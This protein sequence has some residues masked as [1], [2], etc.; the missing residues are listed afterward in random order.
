M[1]GQ[2]IFDNDDKKIQWRKNSLFN[3]GAGT[4]HDTKRISNKIKINK[5]DFISITLVI[6]QMPL[7]E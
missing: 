6:Q 1:Y 7:G 4:R 2:L 5:L 3:N